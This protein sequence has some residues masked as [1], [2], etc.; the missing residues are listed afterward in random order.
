MSRSIYWK[1]AIPFTALILA[2]MIALGFYMVDSAR[3]TQIHQ[4]ESQLTNEAKLIA[5]IAAPGFIEPTGSVNL[6]ALAKNTGNEIGT[7]VT[8]I[9][10]NGTVL[11]DTDQNPAVMENHATRPEV[12]A[13]LAFGTGQATRYSATL[14]ETMMY[15]AVPVRAS[16]E[17]KGI[18]R[19]ALPLT[20]VEGSVR[21]TVITIILAIAT[22]TL[23]LML[24]AVII[25]RLITRPVRQITKAAEGIAAGK[26]DQQI[27]IKSNDEIGRLGRAFNEMSSTIKNNMGAISREKGRLTAIMSGLTD[28]VVMTDTEG[29]IV[30]ANPA[31][32][33]L[34]NFQEKEAINRR[35]IEV[36][37]DHE[38]D[39]VLKLCLK[40]G[41]TQSVQFETTFS[42]RFLRAIAA[43]I[44]EGG[45]SGALLLFQDLT[46]LRN[47]Q[48]MRRE[49]LGNISHDL[50]T[51][52]AGIKAMV[53]TLQGN[54]ID[55]REAA[56]DFLNRIDS[57]IDRL[58]QMV[59]EIT[60]LSRIETGKAELELAP[61]NLNILIEGAIIQ[62]NPLAE[63]QQV[64]IATE[65]DTNLPNTMADG[66]RIRQTI[67]NLV[68]NA[69]KFNHSGG[70]VTVST[71]SNKDSVTVNVA[72]T[73]TG[74]AKDDLPRV[75]ERFYKSDKSRSRGGSG[76]GLAIA[77]HT[78]QAHGG[79]IQAQSE[80]GK[81]SIFSFTL[82]IKTN[83]A[84]G[85]IKI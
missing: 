65:L 48:T 51:P 67:I 21:S 8:L 23:L 77:K 62:L 71:Q 13:A 53:E 1:I 69:I 61:T 76:L 47:L 80:E 63:R 81:G 57:E 75:F 33:K 6:D 58:T 37:R 54:T 17:V 2:G 49:L 27:P 26:L 42:K 30:L 31:G 83:P 29:K 43:P 16:G 39:D 20:T 19:V 24:A 50:R 78:I 9:A 66:D 7:R 34:F 22:A 56:Q 52:L 74:I 40:T 36:V 28:G 41:Q 18:S 14:H 25:A 15:V 82:P 35:L 68:H 72:D 3:N 55:D 44:T 38:A 12:I 11:G 32:E 46:E 79:T 10:L 70:K 85:N 59:S 73:G 5:D 84:S 45:L 64:T 4:L 60:E